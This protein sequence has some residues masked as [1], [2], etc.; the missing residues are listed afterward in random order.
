MRFK[1]ED[2]K[3]LYSVR[4]IDG[5]LILERCSI[6]SYIKSRGT[7]DYKPDVIINPTIEINNCSLFFSGHRLTRV[8]RGHYKE[9]QYHPVQLTE[10]RKSWSEEIFYSEDD[11]I[12]KNVVEWK[13]NWPFRKRVVHKDVKHLQP[14]YY[15]ETDGI[16]ETQT[17]SNF[18][19][20]DGFTNETKKGV[21]TG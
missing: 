1:K 11:I 18:R 19:F 8:K 16:F 6:D 15:L 3:E 17:T 20:V 4:V 2:I 12:E 5:T 14:A 7:Y 9:Y 10:L 13:G 21:I